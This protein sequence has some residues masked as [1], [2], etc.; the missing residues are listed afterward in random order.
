MFLY[1]ELYSVYV[2]SAAYVAP[3]VLEFI[4]S[5]FFRYFCQF[6]SFLSHKADPIFPLV[7][8]L[9]LVYCPVFETTG[10]FRVSEAFLKLGLP[11]VH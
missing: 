7:A 11:L 1:K 8:K 5:L 6:F 10:E 9:I 4:N 3:D 2:H